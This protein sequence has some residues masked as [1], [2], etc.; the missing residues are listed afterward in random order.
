MMASAQVLTPDQRKQAQAEL[1]KGR[2]HH[3]GEPHAD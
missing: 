1:A 3:R 2:G